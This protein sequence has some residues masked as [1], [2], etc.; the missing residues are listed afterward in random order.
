MKR[1]AFY[2]LLIVFI[3][4]FNAIFYIIF[5][6][7]VRYDGLGGL[8][9]LLIEFGV[10]F[11][12]L[13][14]GS[15]FYEVLHPIKK[16]TSSLNPTEV[17][18]TLT[19]DT[20]NTTIFK[21]LGAISF[22]IFIICFITT[23]IYIWPSFFNSFFFWSPYIICRLILLFL[24]GIAI[25]LSIKR[26][27]SSRFLVLFLIFILIPMEFF[28]IGFLG[29]RAKYNMYYNTEK[30]TNALNRITNNEAVVTGDLNKCLQAKDTT[31][32][33]NCVILLANAKNDPNLCSFFDDE[34]NS[35]YKQCVNDGN[36]ETQCGYFDY[37]FKNNKRSCITDIAVKND[38]LDACFKLIDSND[39]YFKNALNTILR[40][41]EPIAI[42]RKDISICDSFYEYN[43]KYNIWTNDNDLNTGIIYAIKL[44][45]E[46]IDW[47]KSYY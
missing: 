38:D 44:C 42:K 32:R 46:Q 37:K 24:S 43:K 11:T 28:G 36:N 6:S 16:A 31:D 35:E 34:N 14:F 12:I 26:E 9:P 21:F 40:C 4:I 8:I 2:L 1:S 15:I 20:E 39:F 45:K 22:F 19:T 33:E 17:N 18:H 7:N 25:Y 3:G 47:G 10:S 30:I 41:V 29:Q 27:G 5:I 23:I 13:V